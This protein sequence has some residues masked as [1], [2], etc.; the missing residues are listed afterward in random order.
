[1]SACHRLALVGCGGMGRRHL[2]GYRVLTDYEPGRIEVAA[3]IDSETERAEFVA[4][5]AEDLFGARPR[6][7]RSLGDAIA[8]VPELGVVDVV[9]SA[10]AHHAV[11]IADAEAGLHVLCEKPMSPTVA[12]CRAMQ[13]AAE[14]CGTVLSIA[15]NYRR[16]PV[17]R[18]AAELLG[19]GAIGEIRTVMDIGAGGGRTAAAGGWQYSRRHGGAV[20]EQAVHNADMQMYLAGPVRHVTGR[21]RLQEQERVFRDA[22][23]KAYHEH[24]SDSYPDTLVAD[25]PDILMGTLEFEC[26]ALG[27]WVHDQAAHGPGF[28]RFTMYGSEGQMDLPSVRTGR[29]LSVFRDG[30]SGALEDEDVLELVPDFALDE[31][32]ARYFG[33]ERLARYDVGSGMGG[34]A[35]LRILAMEIAELLDAVEGG[36][37]VEVGPRVGLEAGALVM[38]C[39]E[40]SVEGRTVTMAEVA[41]G[42][43]SSYQDVANSELDIAH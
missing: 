30:H 8:A 15:E 9:V 24:Y 39:H 7:C 21:V 5:E 1:M 36:G 11:A 31:R 6:A 33:G 43:V 2:R 25:A 16:D 18:L 12:G 27:H 42:S 41:D 37:A 28:S 32:T 29:P 14:R 4:G 34:G 23:V 3:V 35:D 22:P 13:A 40:S 20:L 26:G 10:A 17:S 38:A 19:S